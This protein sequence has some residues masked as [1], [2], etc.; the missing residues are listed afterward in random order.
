LDKNDVVLDC[1]NKTFT[2]IDEEGKQITLKGISRPI[3]I[4][5]ILSLQLKI[6]FRK[7]CQLYATHVEETKKTKGTSLEYFSILQ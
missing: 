2:Y 6:C 1:H 3:S 7:G 5:E 4:R